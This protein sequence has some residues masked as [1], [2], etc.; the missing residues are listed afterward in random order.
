MINESHRTPRFNRSLFKSGFLG[1]EFDQAIIERNAQAQ[2]RLEAPSADSEPGCVR[3]I[4][5]A[6]EDVL[7][8]GGQ[9]AGRVRHELSGLLNIAPNAL[10]TIGG[11][12]VSEKH[13]LQHGETVE[14]IRHYGRKG[15]GRVWTQEE[16]C[17][18][19]K[20]SESDFEA[21][22]AK[23]LP[24][25]EMEDRSVRITETQVDEFLDGL[26]GDGSR[27]HAAP[28]LPSYPD[29]SSLIAEIRRIA[30]VMD[31]PAPDIVDS[32]Y[33]A[34]RL[35]CTTTWIAYLARRG[36]IPLAC[37]VVGTGDG[38]PWKFRR[39]AIDLWIASR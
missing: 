29:L 27:Y 30:N 38:K 8:L 18:L 14:F 33:V 7:P 36:E 21:M 3:L 22:V 10:A 34:G 2:R 24:M 4:F 39:G 16:F 28:P 5:G 17:V 6:N 12:P 37:L 23:G 11:H 15:V 20:M 32:S 1:H 26:A 9:E 19:F 25:H 13:L 35:G 31:P